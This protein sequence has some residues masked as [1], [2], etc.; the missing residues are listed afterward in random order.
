MQ[1][2]K[3]NPIKPQ[4]SKVY[5]NCE[6]WKSIYVY[7]SEYGLLY[8]CSEKDIQQGKFEIRNSE[9]NKPSPKQVRC[10]NNGTIYQ[11]INAASRALGVYPGHILLVL[12]GKSKHAKG[13]R[14]EYVEC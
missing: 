14:F 9:Y 5:H 4:N 8:L 3:K 13:Y 1:I 2:I 11:S 6:K 7:R 12:K 10:L